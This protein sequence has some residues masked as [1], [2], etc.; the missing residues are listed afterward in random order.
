MTSNLI[1]VIVYCYL[2]VGMAHYV[3]TVTD[4]H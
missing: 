4:Y 3:P 2:S 1:D